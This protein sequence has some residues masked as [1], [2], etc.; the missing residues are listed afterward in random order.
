MSNSY[1][2]FV[3]EPETAFTVAVNDTVRYQL[4]ELIDS[5]GNDEPEVNILRMENQED[6]FPGFL[7]FNQETRTLTFTPDMYDGG[8]TYYFTI[9]VKEKNSESVKYPF[10]ATVN[11]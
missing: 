6:R 8:S 4:P 3:T 1:P 9:V 11:V 2:D 7:D 10:Y 5:E